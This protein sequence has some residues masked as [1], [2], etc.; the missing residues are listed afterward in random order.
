MRQFF[1]GLIALAACAEPA[2]EA[3]HP[4]GHDFAPTVR[5]ATF[6][7]SL[8]RDAPGALLEDLRTNDGPQLAAVREIIRRVNPD[9]LVLNEFDY[10]QSEDSL[11]LFAEQLG[12]GYDYQ[13]AIPSNTGV[14]SGI[15]FDG[16]GTSDHPLGA[17][18]YGNDSFGY[19]IH[20]GQYAF[21]VLS[22]YPI[23][24][25]AV[26]TFQ[27]LLWKD[28]P[29]NLLPTD[30]YSEEAQGVFRLSSK[31]HADVPIDVEGQTVHMVLAH[32]T[33]P[34]FDGPEDRNGR[35]NFDE[36]RLVHHY[37]TGTDEMWLRDDQGQVGGL[38]DN[39]LFVVAGDLNAD[40]VDG[41]RPEGQEK[42]AI[43]LLIEHPRIT[44]PLPM[45]A[46]GAD[47]AQRQGGGNLEQ[48]GDHRLDTGDFNDRYV[49]NL[50]ID[51]VLPSSN[52]TVLGSGVFWP[53]EDEP[54]YDL[55]GPGYPPVSSDHRLVWVDLE[56]PPTP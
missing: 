1:L 41:D 39:A 28:L 34:G 23:D 12:Q 55:V 19:G 48:K 50:R 2:E 17:R 32:P 4:G 5:V 22:R 8:Y 15:D 20:P 11:T 36:L 10:E 24:R 31:N 52:M 46:G 51:Y 3:P 6:N 35:R 49:G 37:V 26:R 30:F 14:P 9:I 16:D 45:S 21:A 56:L 43:Q 27:K 42:H 33:P 13:I 38:S 53:A 54:G 18:E 40:P 44:D 25:E 29:D 7:V 47:A